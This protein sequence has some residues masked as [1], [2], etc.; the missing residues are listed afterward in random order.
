VQL[1]TIEIEHPEV[2]RQH[3]EEEQRWQTARELWIADKVAMNKLEK[4]KGIKS[5]QEHAQECK[6]QKAKRRFQ[7]IGFQTISERTEVDEY[8]FYCF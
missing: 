2:I 6:E 7:G 8:L 1:L 5:K 4:Q 3:K